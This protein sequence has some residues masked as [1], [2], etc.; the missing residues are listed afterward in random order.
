MYEGH[1]YLHTK[2]IFSQP[3]TLRHAWLPKSKKY[4]QMS[5]NVNAP[6]IRGDVQRQ[7]SQ[8]EQSTEK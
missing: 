8:A 3:Y 1:H 4:A 7:R 2:A 6:R 5:D